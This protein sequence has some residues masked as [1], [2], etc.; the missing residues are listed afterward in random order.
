MGLFDISIDFYSDLL[1][2]L[3]NFVSSTFSPGCRHGSFQ[4]HGSLGNKSHDFLK[5]SL[6]GRKITFTVP[7]S[8]PMITKGEMIRDDVRTYGMYYRHTVK[9]I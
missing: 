1:Y 2:H 7:T 4:P 6:G 9:Y 3:I 8:S 5:E